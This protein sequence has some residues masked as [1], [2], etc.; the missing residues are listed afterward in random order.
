MDDPAVR[1]DVTPELCRRLYVRMRVARR[2][3]EEAN[4]LQRQGELGLW[5]M[6]LGQEAA[7]VGSISALRPTDYVFPSY[8]EHAA[9]LCRGLSPAELL[10]QWRGCRHSG[11]DPVRYRFHINTL[12]LGAQLLHATGYAMGVRL[13]GVDEA[14]LAYFGDGASSQGE[15]NE[16]FNWAAVVDAPI[17][18]FCQNN[19]WAIS[20][21][22][23]QQMRSPLHQRG[24][25]FGLRTEIVD[26]NDVL[27]VYAV[28][29]AVV[30]RIRSGDGPALIEAVTYRRAGHST[31]DD[32]R[33]YRSAA[34][35]E[36][37]RAHDPLLRLERLLERQGWTDTAHRMEVDA[38][39]EQFAIRT[40]DECRS[41][42]EPDLGA[43]FDTVLVDAPTALAA[44]RDRQLRLAGPVD[45]CGG[46]Q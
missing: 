21:P 12:M 26:G 27:A 15:A 10:V 34:E 40:R 9:A 31:A 35:E 19:Q 16:A 38:R 6:A 18:F 22:T 42:P 20:T 5:A 39:C 37:W 45:E 8:R 25:G 4:A 29:R 23:A 44:E 24:A 2:F 32:P 14:V 46:L 3:D 36:S 43:L 7:Q 33:R 28:T 1:L 11:W 41:L 17:V 13:D 30:D